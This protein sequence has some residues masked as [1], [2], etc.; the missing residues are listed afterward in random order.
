MMTKH[1]LVTFFKK[2]VN[3][4]DENVKVMLRVC[5]F[6]FVNLEIIKYGCF[7]SLVAIKKG[8]EKVDPKWF[9]ICSLQSFFYK[10]QAQFLKYFLAIYVST[11]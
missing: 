4:S 2:R 10:Y 8:I 7:L 5:K 11:A 3:T 9:N 1:H 6:P